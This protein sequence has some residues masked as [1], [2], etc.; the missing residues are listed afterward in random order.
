MTTWP[1]TSTLSPVGDPTAEDHAPI[2]HKPA[3]D[4]ERKTLERLAA[5]PGKRNS[6]K[7]NTLLL[8][9][10]HHTRTRQGLTRIELATLM[11]TTRDHVHPRIMELEK[12]GWVQR[13]PEL[14]DSSVV[15]IP[16]EKALM[17]AEYQQD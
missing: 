1:S 5:N 4:A 7:R 2:S 10:R 13:H 11:K 9:C 16:T 15:Y 17:W 14:R 12:G 3:T 8:L 6:V